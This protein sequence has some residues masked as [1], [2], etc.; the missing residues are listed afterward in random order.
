MK[1]NNFLKSLFVS[2]AFL[3][4]SCGPD[5]IGAC[6]NADD[7]NVSV[8]QVVTFSNCS[9]LESKNQDCRWSFG[10][11]VDTTVQGN[12]AVKHAYK[13]TGQFEV[14]LSIGEGSKLSVH[15]LN[16]SVF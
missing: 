2:A 4:M 13:S 8:N 1:K 12:I 10:D 15:T 6:F 3:M 11:G 16:L 7:N 9:S 14:K 5:D